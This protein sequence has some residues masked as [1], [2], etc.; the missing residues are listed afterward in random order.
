MYN[1][2]LKN[3][4]ETIARRIEQGPLLVSNYLSSV[5][6]NRRIALKLTLAD[7][8]NNICSEAFL[9]KLERN[10]M[11]PVNDRVELI[12]ERL[13][14]DYHTLINLDSN[15][16]I[17]QLL[18]MFIE[19]KYDEIIELNDQT[20]EGIFIAQDEIIKSYKHFINKDFKSLH[21]SII[22]LD[23]VKDCL[24]EIELFALLLIVF[25]TYFY[26]MQYKKAYEY[27]NLIKK[28]QFNDKRFN[29]FIKE[30]K[31][32]LSCKMGLDNVE[33]L[34]DEIRKEFHLFT[35]EKQFILL[36]HYY[37]TFDTEE[38]Y[39]YICD[40]GCK[41]IPK[42]YREEYNYAKVFLLT[43]LNRNLEA[44]KEVIECNSFHI[45]FASIFAYNLLSYSLSDTNELEVKKYKS[46]LI[47]YIKLCIQTTAE[48]YHIAFLRLMQY[49]IDGSGSEIICNFIKNHLLKELKEYSYPLYD[50]YINDRYCL[51]LG[52]LCRYKD[53]YL[54]LLESKMDLKK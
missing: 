14:L 19:A 25:E 33:Y 50:K 5:I 16:R 17:E 30:R 40:M 29:L 53:A 22:D 3:I 18:T 23:N 10:M 20:I 48:T 52:K 37:E 38:A 28:V 31:F 2:Y 36:L 15:N 21:L 39:K 49:E 26:T 27:I 9:S 42:I 4:T 46:N 44:M 45:K 6:K 12:C 47:N 34:F 13:D 7:T 41:Y 32:I 54:Y 11:N 24:S 1:I 51:L 35:I 43:K 8:T